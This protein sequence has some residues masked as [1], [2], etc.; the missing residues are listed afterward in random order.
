M[1]VGELDRNCKG[2]RGVK[3]EG[4]AAKGDFPA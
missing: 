1:S 2:V 3:R 4:G